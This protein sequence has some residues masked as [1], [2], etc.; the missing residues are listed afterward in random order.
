MAF[1][2]ETSIGV[3]A[4]PQHLFINT[5]PR[6]SDMLNQH[7]ISTGFSQ[8][9]LFGNK[10]LYANKVIKYPKYCIPHFPR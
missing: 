5:I 10:S 4:W 8:F 7:P 2:V 3:E 1:L 9:V 6:D